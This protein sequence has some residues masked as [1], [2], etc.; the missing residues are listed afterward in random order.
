MISDLKKSLTHLSVPVP[1]VPEG[2]YDILIG[3]DFLSSLRPALEAQF[4]GR[5]LFVVTDA[6]LVK[7][8]HV[9]SL[10]GESPLGRFTTDQV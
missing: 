8:G 4:A 5:P 2:H 1:L 3:R 9:E 10:L 6:D 7:A